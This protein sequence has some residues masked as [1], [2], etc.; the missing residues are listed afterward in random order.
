MTLQEITPLIEQLAIPDKI[1][2][3]ELLAQQIN[4][5]VKQNT[6]LQKKALQ[7]NVAIKAQPEQTATFEETLRLVLDRDKTVWAELAT[8]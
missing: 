5:L 3:Y 8:K 4:L 6:A 2:V 1:K 7:T